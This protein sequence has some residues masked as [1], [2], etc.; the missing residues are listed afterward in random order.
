MSEKVSA[1]TY[2][3]RCATC[4]SSPPASTQAFIELDVR[5]HLR[6]AGASDNRH[7]EHFRAI[8]FRDLAAA[9][10][11]YPIEYGSMEAARLLQQDTL[12]A[13]RSRE[14]ARVAECRSPPSRA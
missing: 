9:R 12:D 11:R 2:D 13:L 5:F 10:S 14:R 1:A 4:S 6:I 7:L 8:I 3:R